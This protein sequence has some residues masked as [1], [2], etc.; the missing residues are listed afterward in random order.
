[1]G[2]PRPT[3]FYPL[4]LVALSFY[5][6]SWLS[7]RAWRTVHLL[8]YGVYLMALAHGVMSGTDSGSPWVR[9]VYWATAGVLL[10]LTIY[11]I[12]VSRFSP[13]RAPVRPAVT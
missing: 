5:V 3:G 9:A 7:N 8:S 12:L 11:R 10:F 2:G 13:A 6:R 4:A 1:M